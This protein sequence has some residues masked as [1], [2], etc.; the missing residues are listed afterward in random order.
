MINSDIDIQRHVRF[1]DA[2]IKVT[3]SVSAVESSQEHMFALRNADVTVD[4]GVLNSCYY[5]TMGFENYWVDYEVGKT[6]FLSSLKLKNGAELNVANTIYVNTGSSITIDSTSQ[7]TANALTLHDGGI[8]TIDAAGFVGVKKIIDLN[9]NVS[10][11]G[12]VNVINQGDTHVVFGADGD[13]TL[14][15]ANQSTVYVN[16]DYS[17]QEAVDGLFGEN[18]GMIYDYN[19]FSTVKAAGK[20]A[21]SRNGATIDLGDEKYVYA[22]PLTNDADALTFT[23]AGNYTITGGKGVLLNYEFEIN[24][25]K[26]AGQYNVDI[27]NA[28]VTLTKF[29]LRDNANVEITDS[30]LDFD[31]FL[32]GSWFSIYR[33]SNLTVNGSIIGYSANKTGVADPAEFLANNSPAGK[34]SW[35]TVLQAYGDAEFN[36]SLLFLTD[37]EGGHANFSVKGNGNVTFNDSYISNALFNVGFG[38]VD[39]KYFGTGDDISNL[40]A[41]LTISGSTVRSS[42]YR[43]DSSSSGIRVGDAD[44]AGKLIIENSDVDMTVIEYFGNE[45]GLTVNNAASSVKISGSTVKV[46]QVANGG[47]ITVDALS[48]ITATSLT[49]SGT[50]NLIGSSM[51]VTGDMESSSM[52]MLKDSTLTVDGDISFASGISWMSLGG[53]TI[54][55]GSNGVSMNWNSQIVVGGEWT[56]DFLPPAISVDLTGV[57]NSGRKV[58]K[59]ID[60]VNNNMSNFLVQDDSNLGEWKV[61]IING[62]M[63]LFKSDKTELYIDTKCANDEDGIMDNGKIV[64]YNAFATLDYKADASS[65]YLVIAGGT[66]VPA[67]NTWVEMIKGGID[68]I[69]TVDGTVE[70]TDGNLLFSSETAGEYS[71]SG[72]MVASGVSGSWIGTQQVPWFDGGIIRFAGSDGVV[73]NINNADIKANTNLQFIGGTAVIAADAAVGILENSYAGASVYADLT[74][75][76]TMNLVTDKVNGTL[77]IVGHSSKKDT[78]SVLNVSG[79]D[80]KLNLA[81]NDTR[82]DSYRDVNIYGSG[83]MVVENGAVV[84][85]TGDWLIQSRDET[86]LDANGNA[87]GGTLEIN[88][89]AVSAGSIDAAGDI[90]LTNGAELN[91]AGNLNLSKEG[92]NI[93]GTHV[94]GTIITVSAD[95]KLTAQSITF[96][97]SNTSNG[98]TVTYKSNMKAHINISID[99]DMI[100][101]FDQ[102]VYKIIDVLGNDALDMSRVLVN[103]KSSL[104]GIIKTKDATFGDYMI[105]DMG[106]DVFLVKA[107]NNNTVSVNSAWAGTALG[108]VMADGSVYGFNA[109]SNVNEAIGA[110]KKY[111]NSLSFA[112]DTAVTVNLLSDT[113]YECTEAHMM[114]DFVNA[115]G[116]DNVT[117][118]FTGVTSEWISA[119]GFKIGDGVT[120]KMD[121]GSYF[122]VSGYSNSSN[123]GDKH[124]G[125]VYGTLDADYVYLLDT[126]VSVYDGGQMLANKGEATI[127]VKGPTT[128]NVYAG[129]Y[130]ETAILNVW[131]DAGIVGDA[132]LNIAGGSVYAKWLHGWGGNGS[133]T[134]NVTDGGELSS[135]NLSVTQGTKLNVAGSALNVTDTLTNSSEINVSGASDISAKI[136]GTGTVNFADGTVLTSE[137]GLTYEGLITPAGKLTFDD[138]VYS[139]GTLYLDGEATREFV[140]ADGSDVTASGVLSVEG[141]NVAT[142]EAG[143]KFNT[144]AGLVLGGNAPVVNVNGSV[145]D[146][147][148]AEMPAAYDVNFDTVCFFANTATLNLTN[149]AVS[150]GGFYY[151]EAA[152]YDG[153]PVNYTVN[154]NNSQLKIQTYFINTGYQITGKGEWN[155]V[156]SKLYSARN[157][158]Y[159]DAASTMKLT[160]SVADFGGIT[161]DGTITVDYQSLF[162]FNAISGNGSFT[163]DTTG[164]TSGS[165]KVLDYTGT[166]SM[167][168]SF[169][170]GFGTD[171]NLKVIDNDLYVYSGDQKTIY[172]DDTFTADSALA[173][174]KIYG[175]NAV[176][177]WTSFSGSLVVNNVSWGNLLLLPEETEKLVLAG[178]NE[179]SYGMFRTIQDITIETT[180]SDYAVIDRFVNCMGDLTFAANSKVKVLGVGG[181]TGVNNHEHGS[182]NVY[183]DVL[184]ANGS[185]R[186]PLMLWGT[187]KPGN[188]IVHKGGTFTAEAGNVQNYGG[189]IIVKGTMTLGSAGDAP[190]I[191][192]ADQTFDG[193]HLTVDGCDGEGVLTVLH[194]R[195]NMGGGD[196]SGN[197][198][199]DA[200]AG[201]TADIKNG[202]KI[203]TSAVSFRNGVSNTLTMDGGTFTFVNDPGYASITPSYFDNKGVINVLNNS[204]LDMTDRKFINEGTIEISNSKFIVDTFTNSG[205]FESNGADITVGTVTLDNSSGLTELYN[206]D[207]EVTGNSISVK[208]GSCFWVY[209][210]SSL[211][212]KN[213]TMTV[214]NGAVVAVDASSTITLDAINFVGNGCLNIEIY[215]IYTSEGWKTIYNGGVVKVV[216]LDMANGIDQ[217]KVFLLQDENQ[218]ASLFFGEDGDI[219]VTDAVISSDEVYVNSTY[220]GSGSVTS[221]GYIVDIN[222]FNT[223]EAAIASGAAKMTI[224]GGEFGKLSF[225]GTDTTI[226]DGTING[227][228]YGGN[229]DGDA[230]VSNNSTLTIAGGKM[231][232][233]V[234]G[235][236]RVHGGTSIAN[237]GI[238]T[239]SGDIAVNV[240]GGS[241]TEL[242]GGDI[243]TQ[244]V[245]FVRE[246]DINMNISGGVFSSRVHGGITVS[247]VVNKEHMVQ[248]LGD[249]NMNI[250]GGTFNDRVYGGNWAQKYNLSD[251]LSHTGNISVTVNADE[252]IV[253]G[254]HLVIGS[255]GISMIHG[256]VKLTLSGDGSNLKFASNSILLGSSGDSY[257]VL[258][259]SSKIPVSYVDG[260]REIVFDAFQGDVAAEIKMFDTMYLT[261]DSVVSFTDSAINLQE[262]TTWNFESGS[263]IDSAANG[264]DLSGDTINLSG[265]WADGVAFEL[266]SA[267]A[268]TAWDNVVVNYNGVAVDCELKSENDKLIISKLA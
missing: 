95:S 27:D 124:D 163:I 24:P 12:K 98:E 14:V 245:I 216:D 172:F 215:D 57:E 264:I 11:E 130:V 100:S 19:A 93:S 121:D 236:N 144:T 128:L 60:T 91:V 248:T 188:F 189:H 109:F 247:S 30:R 55:L 256:D 175:Y 71:I 56:Y 207:F 164:Y 90:T 226:T 265:T 21:N 180:G 143:A 45:Y 8:L 15:K 227:V 224:T 40:C 200:G 212:G 151:N 5:F 174:G 148:N 156:N 36:N 120:V 42:Q 154:L 267:D 69:S 79:V 103:D 214:N 134:I 7:I 62:D 39:S 171:A 59:L 119:Q 191:C 61:D 137:K 51:H 250:S 259:G 113:T 118:S 96:N 229:A 25:D 198:W 199:A 260:R 254:E 185:N 136:S 131:N 238:V 75:N 211:N 1:T 108:T 50:I 166:G 179:K 262:I 44:R 38:G 237:N 86:A 159:F 149:A 249:I 9:S 13:V 150:V 132:L 266:G 129:G 232:E 107:S 177:D 117:V 205:D 240:S 16:S 251:K 48:S 257:Y 160:G 37:N 181:S 228:V 152:N 28:F 54:T 127:Q 193:G 268:F 217:S 82:T 218:N 26:L 125:H 161:N 35:G 182:V 68:N 252:E 31:P 196:I 204:A 49:N 187:L 83:K 253:F 111:H 194:N 101:G 4:G 170:N 106:N 63:Y 17:S 73:F 142:I 46:T 52:I 206:T 263:I 22:K 176:N 102:A 3:G 223:V 126:T 146:A 74:L 85:S 186:A 246:G 32:S 88:N 203:V 77:L 34:W 242:I 99:A 139:L 147:A 241:F 168:Y 138:G 219:Y 76:G 65:K 72:S 178:G 141:S 114:L 80:A 234:Y 23:N 94:A 255:S 208:E 222:A 2:T 84:N 243:V 157:D 20:Q 153:K 221:D 58:F 140:F 64:G 209:E 155:V 167:D 165:Y 261:G 133:Q 116:N 220:T 258:D 104:A 201:C 202:G 197:V 97:V 53:E 110:T 122:Y 244:A 135:E 18:S 29:T 192:G 78:Y 158:L 89:A 6:D 145:T 195:L 92:L 183:G 87:Y 66:Y 184:F 230:N 162:K 33:D 235:G 233:T 190:K 67:K 213:A 112:K 70:V 105:V 10:L 173:D 210:Y 231:T 81:M 239:V 115:S 41:T 43:G 225:N 169:V 47:T 123:S